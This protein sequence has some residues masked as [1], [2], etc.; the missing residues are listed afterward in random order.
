MLDA[1]PA[2]VYRAFADPTQLAAWWG[3]DGFA[4][5][6]E[7]FRFQVGGAWKF[8]MVSPDG[9]RYENENTFLE[10]VP[11]ERVV[12]QHESAPRFQLVVTLS[13]TPTGTHLHWSQTFEDP[14]VAA[15]V[16]HIVEPA[17]EQNLDRLS[18]VLGACPSAA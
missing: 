6:F 16:K 18:V 3:P 8:V 5:E 2:R 10:L 7:S 9:T 1:T 12:I 17:N 14:Q 15:A 11:G 13:I 4:N